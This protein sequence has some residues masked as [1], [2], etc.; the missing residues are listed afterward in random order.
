MSSLSSQSHDPFGT[1]RW[2]MVLQLATTDPRD[3]GGALTELVQRYWYPVYAYV[4]CDGHAPDEASSIAQGFLE[5]L[6][7]DFRLGAAQPRGHFRRYLLDQL[8]GFLAGDGRAQMEQQAHELAVPADLEARHQRD[9]ALATSPEQAYEHSFA[10]EVMARAITRLRSKA[11]ETG[12]VALFEALLTYLGEEPK[13]IEL[14]RLALR[15]HTRPMALVVALKRLRQRF[16]ELMNRELAD[17]VTSAADLAA[18]QTAL[19]A[20]LRQTRVPP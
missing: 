18:E 8:K 12:N 20:A 4:R 11:Q 1:T 15:L 3:A 19:L 6:M 16:R 7:R 13:A 5:G 17:T 14:E 2:S 10:L 9:N